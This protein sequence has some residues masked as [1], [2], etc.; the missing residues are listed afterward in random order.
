MGQLMLLRVSEFCLFLLLNEFY[1][2]GEPQLA[3]FE[4]LGL[5]IFLINTNKAARSTFIQD[6]VD[7]GFH[8]FQINT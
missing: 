6:F 4:H 1:F 2:M 7:K 8:F 5:K 3:S